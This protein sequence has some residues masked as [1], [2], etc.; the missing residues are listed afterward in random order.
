MAGYQGRIRRGNYWYGQGVIKVRT[1]R[2]KGSDTERWDVG[3]INRTKGTPREPQP[4]VDSSEIYSKIKVREFGEE[5]LREIPRLPEG[6]ERPIRKH[7]FKITKGDVENTD[8][9]KTAT[10]ATEQ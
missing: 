4:G 5:E 6:M 3:G 9:P 2:R 10:G 8:L 1:V 7:R